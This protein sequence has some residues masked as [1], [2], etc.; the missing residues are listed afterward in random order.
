MKT[1]KKF[2]LDTK[3]SQNT[4]TRCHKGG[5][6]IRETTN[7]YKENPFANVEPILEE[8]CNIQIA[9]DKSSYQQLDLNIENYSRNDIFKL[10][11]LQT[12]SLTIDIMKECKKIVLKTHP[13]KSQLDSKYFL[14]FS[15]A[16][17]KLYSVYEFQNKTMK[18]PN[19]M[20]NSNN[21]SNKN[22]TMENEY[23]DRENNSI[24]D[25]VFEKDKGLKESKNFNQWFND[26]FDKHKLEDNPTEAGYGS[27]L[28]SD[29]DIVYIPNVTKNNMTEE[30][31]KRKRH[32]QT[33]VNYTGVNE[34]SAPVFAGSSLMEYNSNFTSNSLF[35]N[36]GIGYTDLKQAYVESVI[37][38]TEADFHK[39]EKFQ[40][41]DEY[42][43]H[44]DNIDVT[45]LSK[46]EATKQLF[47]QDKQKDEESVALAFYYAKQAEKTKKNQ[48]TFWSGLKQ[49]MN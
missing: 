34:T 28:K 36:E 10:F 26:Q 27:W 41:V 31:E 12:N 33:I 7:E 47:Y 40:T 14:F 24:L 32:I 18:Q 44:R 5:I 16:Y 23:Y 9:Y 30:M 43:R 45:P 38:V 1:Y 42:R 2:T 8:P 29:E 49:L 3:Q 19:N 11:G 15:K 48:E 35:A 37:P 6:K 4:M 17:K 13:D 46:E 20:N 39:R 22:H 25:K 21:S